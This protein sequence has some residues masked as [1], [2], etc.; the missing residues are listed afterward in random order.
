MMVTLN[1]ETERLTECPKCHRETLYDAYQQDDIGLAA[2]QKCYCCRCVATHY[3]WVEKYLVPLGV[4]DAGLARARKYDSPQEAWNKWKNATEMIDIL[5]KI[6][7]EKCDE[8]MALK[9]IR[10]EDVAYR[11]DTVRLYFPEPPLDFI[12]E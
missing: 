11:A 5:K 6:C 3:G 10:C 8:E 2:V 9:I 7:R 1:Y 12:Y 4:C